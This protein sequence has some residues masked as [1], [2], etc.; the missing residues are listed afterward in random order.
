MPTN[1]LL[2]IKPHFAQQIFAGTKRF[3]FRRTLFKERGI[4]TVIVYA[5]SPICQVIGEFDIAGIL[6]LEIAALWEQTHEFA[7]ITRPYFE[8]YFREKQIGF[9]IH[10]GATR[11]YSDPLQLETSFHIQRPPQS[12]QYISF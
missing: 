3:E 12:F 4:K 10:I 5:S 6:E 9:A 8:T 1:V 2:S 11:R 7:G